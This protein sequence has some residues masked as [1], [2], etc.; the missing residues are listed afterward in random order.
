MADEALLSKLVFL[1]NKKTRWSAATCHILAIFLL[2]DTKPAQ[3][4]PVILLKNKIYTL[5]VIFLGL[6]A[7]G[8]IIIMKKKLT[9]YP[10]LS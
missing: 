8:G 1:Y 4:V 10:V 9:L 5:L 3:Y 2:P 6:F 7:T